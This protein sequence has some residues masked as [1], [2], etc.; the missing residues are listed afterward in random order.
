MMFD[1]PSVFHL[2]ASPTAYTS[3]VFDFLLSRSGFWRGVKVSFSEIPGHVLCNCVCVSRMDSGIIREGAGFGKKP[4]CAFGPGPFSYRRERGGGHKELPA[5][6]TKPTRGNTL[7]RTRIVGWSQSGELFFSLSFLAT[8]PLAATLI[9]SSALFIMSLML[10]FFAYFLAPDTLFNPWLVSCLSTCDAFT[11]FLSWC[12]R[13]GHGSFDDG[14]RSPGRGDLGWAGCE[15]EASQVNIRL[16]FV[17][18]LL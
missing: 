10:L 6:H 13:N 14:Q 2:R 3:C 9:L 11:F 1:F 17:M 4:G 12:T 16:R 7:L 18:S 15:L 8:S 5:S